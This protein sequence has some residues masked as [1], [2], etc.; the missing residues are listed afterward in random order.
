MNTNTPTKTIFRRNIEALIA[1]LFYTPQIN[2]FLAN[3]L[4]RY[5]IPTLTHYVYFILYVTGIL[6]W[7]YGLRKTHT[8]HCII[9]LSILLIWSC[10]MNGEM[11]MELLEVG[12]FSSTL[13][14]LVFVFFPILLLMLEKINYRRLMK[15]LYVLSIVALALFVISFFLRNI[16]KHLEYMSFSYMALNSLFICYSY[17]YNFSHKRIVLLLCLMATYIIF[18]L[19]CRGATVTLFL[20]ILLITFFYLTRTKK[21]FIIKGIVFLGILLISLFYNAFFLEIAKSA[22]K[23]EYAS[24]TIEKINNNTFMESFGRNY[25]WEQARANIHLIGN[26]FFSD[27]SILHDGSTDASTYAHNIVLEVLLDFG[28]PIGGCIL[29]IGLFCVLKALKISYKTNDPII[30][31]LSL[32]MLCV[33][34]VKHMVSSSFLTSID[35]WFYLGF[36][37]NILLNKDALLEPPKED[38]AVVYET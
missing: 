34:F 32:A 27:Q 2:F 11:I 18:I 9:I 6:T 23:M 33:F 17:I 5:E 20:Y 31:N 36:V 19:G 1:L 38:N 22:E 14:Q 29:L 24:R 13:A 28:L 3:I 35:F 4:A 15:Y 37:A 26:G 12:F 8:M 25:I 10:L 16:D 7:C 21:N 30:L